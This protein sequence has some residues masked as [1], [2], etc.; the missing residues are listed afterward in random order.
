MFRFAEIQYALAKLHGAH[1][2]HLGVMRGR[3]Q[4]FQR[5]GLVPATPGRGKVV[6]YSYDDAL[7]WAFSLELVECGIDPSRVVNALP[8]IWPLIEAAL[9]NDQESELIFAARPSFLI[10]EMIEKQNTHGVWFDGFQPINPMDAAEK[11]VFEV[12]ELANYRPGRAIVVNL[13]ELRQRALKAL[14]ETD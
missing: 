1:P 8:R 2:N 3:L 7:K 14:A 4:H 12:S 9:C 5:L 11:Y 6:S 10:T 13:T